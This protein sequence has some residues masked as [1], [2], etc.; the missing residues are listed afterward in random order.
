MN[1]AV[2]GKTMENVRKHLDF[3][4]VNSPKVFQKLVNKPTYKHRFII[5]ENLVGVEQ[6]KETVELNKPI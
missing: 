5:N 3:K 4:L 6:D 2:Y 1:N